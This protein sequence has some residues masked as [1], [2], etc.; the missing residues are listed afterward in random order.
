MGPLEYVS[1]LAGFYRLD[2][3]SAALINKD[4]DDH[5]LQTNVGAHVT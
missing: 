4:I 5:E 2:K 1:T 3:L